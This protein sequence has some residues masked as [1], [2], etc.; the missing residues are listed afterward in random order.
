MCKG[1]KKVTCTAC[2]GTGVAK[3]VVAV[4]DPNGGNGK[5][6]THGDNGQKTRPVPVPGPLGSPDALVAALK[7]EPRHPS[8]DR[9]VW[10]RLTVAQRDD[11]EEAHARAM[12]RWLAQNA[13]HNKKVS[14][15][16]I[17]SD[18]T[19][20]DDGPGYV[21]NAR[22]VAGVFVRAAVRTPGRGVRELKK[23]A[24]IQVAGTIRDYGPVDRRGDPTGPNTTYRIALADATVEPL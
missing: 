10:A 8:R 15:S 4:K 5:K 19:K 1:E 24:E 17:L 20:R 7:T 11:A 12:V 13:F 3:K 6:P 2:D 22:T 21:L 14:W 16:V 23:G 9:Q 18:L